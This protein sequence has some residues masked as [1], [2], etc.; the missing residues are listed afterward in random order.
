MK[1]LIIIR[2]AK[3]ERPSMGQ[4]DFD[5]R[6]TNRG[7]RQCKDL[8]NHIG[9]IHRNIELVLVSSAA[10]TRMTYDSLSCLFPNARVHFMD[11]LYL[12]S[13]KEVLKILEFHA[14]ENSHVVYIGHN[15]G[16]ADLVCYLIDDNLHVPTSCYFHLELAVENWKEI[17]RGIGISL[18]YFFSHER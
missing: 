17:T 1:E 3:T 5:R 16:L 18:D 9:D 14:A 11:E 6:L 10:R 12:C 7:L 15:F 13:Y 4:R 2:H 8:V